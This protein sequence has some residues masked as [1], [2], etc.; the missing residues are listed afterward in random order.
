MAHYDGKIQQGKDENQPVAIGTH[1]GYV[2]SAPVSNMPR[3]L[4]SRVNLSCT[5]VMR[6]SAAQCKTPV[7]V[8]YDD[9]SDQIK[10][11]Q[12]FELDTLGVS[13][14]DSVHETF[15]KDV[16]F[17]NNHYVVSLSWREH[18]DT[19]TDN[20]ELC[21]GRLKSTLRRLRKNPPLLDKYHKVISRGGGGVGGELSQ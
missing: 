11:D 12:M 8:N 17:E 7:N 3:T 15:F 18:H 9:S 21:V 10:L 4:L 16:Q 14:N 5:H 20:Y 6:V 1:F 13:E 19:L 2:L